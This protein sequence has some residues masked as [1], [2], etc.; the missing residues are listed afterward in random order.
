MKINHPPMLAALLLAAASMAC[1]QDPSAA[2]S[3]A[4]STANVSSNGVNATMTVDSWGGGYCTN[5]T[6]ANTSTAAV[7]SW[8]LVVALNGSTLN[9][10][11]GGTAAVSGGQMTVR[12]VDYT[13][14]IAPNASVTLG[15]CGNGSSQPTLASLEVVGGG[16][17]VNQ[18]LT[19][20]KGGQG[21]GTVTSS[22]AGID[23]GSACSAS[24]SSGA[25]VTLTA[26]PGTGSIFTGWSGACT[27]TATCTVTMTAAQSVMASF[28]TGTSGS[29]LTVLKAGTGSGTV[30]G[31]GISCG[32]TCSATYQA[33]ASVTLTAAAASG[34]TFAGWSSTCAG[35]ASGTLTMNASCTVTATFNLTDPGTVVSV[36]AGGSAAGVFVAD[37]YFSGGSTYTTTNAID[38]T[39]ITGTVPPQ[40]VLQSER[41]GEFTYTIPN[42]TAGTA[43]TVTLYFAE[44]YWTAAGQ[45]T[46]NVSINGT[47]ALTAFD[48]FVAAGGA[49][50]AIA[51][52]FNTTASSSGQV[53][54]QFTKGGGPDNPK[55]CGISVIGGSLPFPLTV[56]KAG[57]GTGTVTSNPAGINC[58]STCTA[59][60]ASGASVVLSAAAASGSTFAG[61]SGAGCTGTSTCT[62]PMTTSQSVT[63]TFNSQATT[64]A[65]TVA[66]SGNG[67]GTVTSN[68]TGINCGSTCTVS[69]ASGTSVTL[70]A[71]AASGSTFGGWS[72]ACTGTGTC[73]ASMTA[74]R[75]V[76]AAFS[77]STTCA[78]P[79]TFRWTS[80]GPLANPKSGWVSLKDFTTVV[81]NGQHLVYATTHDTG[82]TWGSMVFS[83]FTDWPQMASATQ[84]GMSRATVAPTLFYFAPKSIWVLTFQWGATPFRYMTSTNPTNP[85]GWSGEGSLFSGSISSS[86][87]GPI[88]Q[89]VICDSTTCYLFFAGDNGRIYRSSMPIGSFP[90][91]FGAATTIM[92]DTTNNL[93]EAVQV[94]KVQGANQ[95]LMI[96]ESIGSRGRYFRSFTATS[97]SGSWTPLAAS[98][99]SPFAGLSNVTFA[100]GNAWTNDISHGDLVRNNSDQTM[101]IDP[102]NLQMLYQGFDK[103]QSAGDYGLIPYRPAV[104][105]LQR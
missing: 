77:S 61:W 100:N 10:I 81:Y 64:Y 94:Y 20:S 6:I 65:L 84:T 14:A 80:T 40:A 93:F 52:T 5:I 104:L 36:N 7:T 46:F 96:V 76:T 105:T 47:A 24:F 66:K 54:I 97:L 28:G 41:Y 83:L 38:T 60:Y 21:A 11:W 86:S 69:Y 43:Q 42:R 59:T 78:L 16:G 88:D 44:S 90:G 73:V 92:T 50:R 35:F 57:T 102:C 12:P 87:T 31:S 4:P 32:S 8:T 58:G 13:A 95:Y 45:R 2:S 23:C 62:V 98:E 103:N 72:G 89:T 34:S 33:G 22:P 85:N 75:S 56:T 68:P 71:T 1:G 37:A 63:A 53:V 74:A 51:R 49:N 15:F 101:T 17:P 29:T 30:T 91:T 79:T 55:V 18:T 48:I 99:S 25:V 3:L 82:S 70:T 26:S 67:T 27:G 39:Q 9:N 19:V